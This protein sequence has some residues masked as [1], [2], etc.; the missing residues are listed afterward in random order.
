MLNNNREYDNAGK[1]QNHVPFNVPAVHQLRFLK[2]LQIQIQA[3]YPEGKNGQQNVY[4]RVIL[5]G[6]ADPG[7]PPEI[8]ETAGY[9]HQQK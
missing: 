4:Y 9:D 2:I 1:K 3:P 8:I 5:K 7:Q 6:L